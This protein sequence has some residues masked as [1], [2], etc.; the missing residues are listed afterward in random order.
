MRVSGVNTNQDILQQLVLRDLTHV[1][2]SILSYLDM[3]TLCAVEMVSP[4][5]SM[6]VHSSS[7]VYR[8]KVNCLLQLLDI[9]FLPG[10]LSRSFK[11]PAPTT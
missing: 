4:E 8:R 9:R 7:S 5:W 11:S 1:L 6:M 10:E 2:N 3:E